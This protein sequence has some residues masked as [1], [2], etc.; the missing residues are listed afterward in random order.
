MTMQKRK[1]LWEAMVK[2]HFASTSHEIEQ[3][4][5]EIADRAIE[6]L[7]ELTER[8]KALDASQ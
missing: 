1:E 4:P 8:A 6:A 7:K 5:S 3:I 2:W